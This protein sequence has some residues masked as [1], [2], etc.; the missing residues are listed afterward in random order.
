MSKLDPGPMTENGDSQRPAYMCAVQPVWPP[1]Y[2]PAPLHVVIL[3]QPQS[4]MSNTG[5]R[6]PSVSTLKFA[7]FPVPKIWLILGHGI[8]ASGVLDLLTWNWC[9]VCHM[10]HEQPS[11]QCLCLCCFPSS[12]GQT[13]N[14]TDDVTLQYF[15]RL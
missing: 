14:G 13:C 12:Y 2:T 9:A 7:G 10:R 11:Y 3:D 15:V 4:R 5:I 8:Y 1:Q 6:A